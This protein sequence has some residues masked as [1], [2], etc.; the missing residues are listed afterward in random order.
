LVLLSFSQVQSGRQSNDGGDEYAFCLIWLR[1]QGLAFA[2]HRNSPY[3]LKDQASA[4]IIDDRVASS[5]H[6]LSHM[7]Y[8]KLLTARTG[9]SPGFAQLTALGCAEKAIGFP[10]LSQKLIV[11][12]AASLWSLPV[13]PISPE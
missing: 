6:G 9:R 10:A 2:E 7:C 13:L 5:D 4:R 1:G 12:A 8:M 11:R 3:H